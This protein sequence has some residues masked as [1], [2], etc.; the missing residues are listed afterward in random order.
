MYLAIITLP[1]LGSIVSGFFGRKVGVSGAQ[2][3]TC[4]SVIV[5]TLLA[6]VA[7]FEVGLNNIPVSVNLFRWIDSESLNVLWGFR[8]DSLTVSMLLPVLIVSSLVHIYSVSYMSHDPRGRVRGK[9]V[10]GDKLSNSGDILKLKVPSCSWKTI[11]GW[12]NYS[13][14]VTSLNMKETEMDYRGSK[15]TILNSMVVKEQRVDGSWS[16]K[17]RLV[18][19]KC[20]LGGFERNRGIKLGF[21]M[22][23]GWNSSVKIPSKQFDLKKFS[24][25]NSTIINPGVWSGL[26]D[27]E[28]SFSIIVDRNKTR[29]LGWRVEL[30]FQLGLHTKDLNLLYLLQEYLGGIGSIHLARNRE[31]V[32]YVISSIEDLNKL[33]IHLE[34]YP[35]LTKKSADFL[36]FKQ[37]VKLVNNK[38]HLTLEGLNQ[39]VNIKASMNLGLS[40]ML[41][42]EFAGY[43]PVE[44]PVINSDNVILDPH[45]ISGFVSAEGNFD[46]RMPSTNSKLGYRVQLRFRISQHSRDLRLMEKIVEYFGSGKIYKYGGKSAVSLTILDFTDITNIIVPFFNKNPI[47]GVKLYDYLDWSKIH[48]LM[49]NRSHLT[50]EGINSIRKI[51]LGMNTGRNFLDN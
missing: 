49:I 34:E 31:I 13:G 7:F 17:P 27:G 4:T 44:R 46:V 15:S 33:I 43:I 22:Q 19:L 39:I 45:W 41:K 24:T 20:I 16:I 26:I 48:S 28:G 37:A 38:A 36:L 5:T 9:R 51:K 2:L 14:M 30:K 40:E 50:V 1:L 8:F 42:S 6:I 47:I 23:Q 11:S 35:L 12:S 3:I 10:Y 29:K 32:N 25:Y 21:N 18:D